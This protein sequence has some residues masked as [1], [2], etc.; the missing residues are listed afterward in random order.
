[1]KNALYWIALQ[2]ALGYGCRQISQILENFD[3][4]ENLFDKRIKHS[5]VKFLSDK[6]FKNIK[7]ADFKKAQG[8]IDY[9]DRKDI[10]IITL[11]DEKYP[12]ILRRIINP[13][14]VLYVRGTFPNFDDEVGIGMVGTRKCSMNGMI[15]AS[16]LAYRMAQAGAIVISGG[17][18]GIDTK[19]SQGAI[20]AKKPSVII[21]P[22]GVDYNYL[23]DL[24]D[25]RKQVE[26]NG[27]VIS[28]VQPLGRVERNAFQIRNRLISALSLGLVVIEA[29]L[30][31]G[32]MITVAYSL[33]YGKDIFALPGDIA[34]EN[35]SGSNKLLQEGATPI[36]A[37]ADV[38]DEYLNAFP[39]RLNLNKA[40]IPINE[41]DIYL[42]LQR[43]YS[44]PTRKAEV[45][46]KKSKSL[47]KKVK[48]KFEKS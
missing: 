5:N 4:I 7:T 18:N 47:V 20:F 40:G 29:P 48:E 8:I 16:T 30:K 44:R 19:C 2:S 37:P 13:P 11:D 39:H 27:A 31:S 3:D 28:E 45:K 26:N 42:R 46:Q 12:I 43:K 14:C 38:L 21:R 32:T 25:I 23:S 15:A 41:D 33:E 6:Q 35:Y 24:R 36:Y 17:A 34:D 9:C 22:C 1:M 10:E